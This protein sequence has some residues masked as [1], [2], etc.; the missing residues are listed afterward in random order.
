LAGALLRV[1]KR[2][3]AAFQKEDSRK[4]KRVI[5]P[6]RERMALGGKNDRRRIYRQFK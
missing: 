6:A 5:A 4:A 3:S 2:K 1:E